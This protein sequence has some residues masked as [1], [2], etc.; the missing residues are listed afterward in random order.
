MADTF[1]EN[2]YIH[3]GGRMEIVFKAQDK[4]NEMC[5][6]LLGEGVEMA[7]CRARVITEERGIDRIV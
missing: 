7:E 6:R 1:I 3:E 2:V 5:E 4:V